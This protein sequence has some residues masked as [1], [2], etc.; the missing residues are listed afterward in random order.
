[1]PTG[2]SFGEEESHAWQPNTVGVEKPRVAR[3]RRLPWAEIRKPFRL[4]DGW[5]DLGE[6]G[7]RQNDGEQA[8]DYSWKSCSAIFLASSMPSSVR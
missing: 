4:V 6:W 8:L 7:G 5:Q 1:M 3:L 2:L